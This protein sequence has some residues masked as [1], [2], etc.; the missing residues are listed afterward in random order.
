MFQWIERK[1]T[2][3]MR[4]FSSRKRVRKTGRTTIVTAAHIEKSLLLIASAIYQQ[5]CHLDKRVKLEE[6]LRR[7]RKTGELETLPLHNFSSFARKTSKTVTAFRITENI[8]VNSKTHI[9]FSSKPRL[10][11]SAT[12]LITFCRREC[13]SDGYLQCACAYS[14]QLF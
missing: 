3:A 7:Q 12:S 2:K 11:S 13:E 1:E 5:L 8:S 4:L 6:D 9:G 14:Q 10:C